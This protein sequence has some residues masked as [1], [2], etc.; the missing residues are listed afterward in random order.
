MNLIPLPDINS[1][2]LRTVL[3]WLQHHKYDQL[4]DKNID[5]WDMKF[6]N[7]NNVMDL[8]NAANYLGI[9]RLLLVSCKK[10]A[11]IVNDRSVDE[12]RN[13]LYWCSKWL[14]N[15]PRGETSRLFVYRG[16]LVVILN[17]V[18]KFIIKIS[19]FSSS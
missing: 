3:Q 5:D 11:E 10:F 6:I 15:S 2:V 8:M 14:T 17:E 1:S 4:Q 18:S 13:I 12:V 7:A 16:I 9:I 19:S